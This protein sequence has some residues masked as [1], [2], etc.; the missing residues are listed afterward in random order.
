MSC[1]KPRN[2][3]GLTEEEFLAQYDSGKYERPSVTVDMLIF[4]VTDVES[5]NYRKL[6]EKALK[7]L[8]DQERRPSLYWTMGSSG[9]VCEYGREPG[10]AAPTVN[11]KRRPEWIK[12]ILSS[13]IPG[14]IGQGSQNPGDKHLL[15][16]T[17]RQL[18]P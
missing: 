10:G 18:R 11:L 8:L 12:F 3:M 5:D 6:P 17:D 14:V 15:P 7:L 4:T 16:L 2:K 9:Q 13:C 1:D